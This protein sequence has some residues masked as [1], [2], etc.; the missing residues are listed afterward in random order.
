MT[1]TGQSTAELAEILRSRLQTGDKIEIT[2]MAVLLIGDNINAHVYKRSATQQTNIKKTIDS[3]LNPRLDYSKCANL[4]KTED[5]VAPKIPT[6]PQKVKLEPLKHKVKDHKIS[7][8]DCGP[9]ILYPIIV[10]T[11]TIL[12]LIP[13]YSLVSSDM[14]CNTYLQA[15]LEDNEKCVY[16]V[17]RS[18]GYGLYEYAPNAINHAAGLC[19]VKAFKAL[20][21]VGIDPTTDNNYALRHAS[22]NGCI[23]IVQ[24]LVKDPRVNLNDE[25]GSPLLHAVANGHIR[26]VKLLLEEEHTDPT[27]GYL[28]SLKAAYHFGHSDILEMLIQ[29]SRIKV[30]I[31]KYVDL[32]NLAWSSLSKVEEKYAQNSDCHWQLQIYDI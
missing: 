25:N 9:E 1:E 15:A 2:P 23:D 22:K 21:E 5:L 10:V 28:R 18:Y 14:W 31:D 27:L 11:V 12:V 20:L 29:D 32:G 4:Q 6:E 3:R 8:F 7:N 24:L 13:Y 19:H 30:I 17:K 26:I 16:R